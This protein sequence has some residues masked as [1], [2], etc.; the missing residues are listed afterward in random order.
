[1]R[2]AKMITKKID[3]CNVKAFISPRLEFIFRYEMEELI[4]Y[5]PIVAKEI[6]G[7]EKIPEVVIGYVELGQGGCMITPNTEIPYIKWEKIQ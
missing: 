4:G 5:I 3:N 6:Y 1:M 7:L 2:I